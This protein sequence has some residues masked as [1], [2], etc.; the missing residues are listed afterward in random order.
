MGDVVITERLLMDAGGW[1]AMKHAKALFQM[2]R[3]SAARYRP[4]L[5]Q[6]MVRDGETDYRGGLK[7]NTA[8]DIE[9]LCSCRPSRDFGAICAHSLAVGLSWIASRTPAPAPKP[10]PAP[11]A[12]VGPELVTEGEAPR[13]ELQVVIAPNFAATWSRDQ[14]MAGFEV[15]Q[16]GR[17]ILASALPVDKTFACTGPEKQILEAARHL[18]AGRLPGMVSMSRD[19]FLHVLGLLTGFPRVTLGRNQPVNVASQPFI[20]ELVAT[21]ETDGALGLT[22]RIGPGQLLV[23]TEKAWHFHD[24]VFRPVAPGLPAPYL[25]L[26]KEPFRM[27]A[28]QAAA[29][30][31][32]ELP[33]LRAF[34]KTPDLLGPAPVEPG[35]PAV[36]ATIEGSL[37]HLAAKLQFRY[38]QRI[39]THGVTS[40]RE[41]FVYATEQGRRV[42]NLTFEKEA[43]E[44]LA[45][46][47][48]Q[49]PGA[50]GEFV[51]KGERAILNFFAHDLPGLQ[52]RWQVSL[53]SR[54]QNV[55]RN[56]DRAQPRLDIV[57]SGENW[58]EFTF[59]LESGQGDHFSAAEV[60]RLLQSGQ[61]S[62][63]RNNG[64][65]VV[66]DPEAL[67]EVQAALVDCQ[68]DQVQPGR[69]RI[70]SNQAAFLDAA[71]REL[72]GGTVSGNPAWDQW[73]ARQRQLVPLT[74]VPLGP[75]T[76]V[77]RDYQ[78]QGV[79]WMN[80]IGANALGGILADEMGLGKT[81]QA[82]AYLSTLP[83]PSLVVCPAS[84]LFNWQREAQRFVPAMKLLAIE[85]PDRAARFAQ[86]PKTNLVLTSYPLLRRDVERYRPYEFSAVVLD[87]ANHIKNPDTQNAHA[88]LALRGRHRFVLTGT[89]VENS[90]RDLWSLM[91]FVL[92]G[93]LGSRE[94]FRE[95]YELP[96]ARGA[97]AEGARLARRLRPVMLR[98]LKKD[99]VKELP[100]KI[101]QVAL[102]E[103]SGAQRELYDKLHREGRRKIE[104]LETKGAGQARMAMLTVLLRLRQVCCDVRLLDAAQ[105]AA[106]AKVDLLLELLEEAL[107]GGHRVLVFS[108]FVTM[109][110][111][112]RTELESRGIGYAYLDG[113]TKQRSV[114]IDRFQQDESLPVFLI[115]LKAGGVGLNLSA[116]DTVF[117]FDPWWNPAVEDQ[118]TDRAHR[119]GQ[120]RVVTS[121]KLIA[122][123]TVEEKIIRLQEKKRDVTEAMLDSEEPLMTGLSLEEIAGLLS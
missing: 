71:V 110:K 3:V 34:L 87:E 53:G 68:P 21:T 38:G 64:R 108:Q 25:T 31:Q 85:G 58:F 118:A 52:L 119:I 72:A 56:L 55:S 26:L 7:V 75:L 61:N 114:E 104:S 5:L 12:R 49:G 29:F 40:P 37:N 122:R 62:V 32:K 106:S 15:V 18:G 82:L 36:L 47:G 30:L 96:I 67:A 57:S 100:G 22:I 81:L 99:V 101:E 2:G 107:D 79:A 11:P 102:C 8:T 10:V 46:A 39:V 90:V 16:S 116:A 89:P 74:S 66:F 42:R 1:Q 123:D 84:L 13:L 78:K 65:K 17:R 93:Y 69:Y 109:L 9:N 14:V 59:S 113:S 91:N 103:L 48:F 105:P 60:Q 86:I 76:D 33:V 4:P 23:G 20:P 120:T 45:H 97:P 98:R 51:L 70:P 80:F 88:A 77:L 54:F 19:H 94:D 24:S 92:P 41:D 73:T 63:S 27:P 43:A 115:S 121:Y 50:N 112:L 44:R 95:R 35:I 83:G 28:E 6:G 117:H 111:L